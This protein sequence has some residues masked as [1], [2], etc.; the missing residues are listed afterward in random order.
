MTDTQN[1]EANEFERLNT[2]LKE[3][4]L[5]AKDELESLAQS[6]SAERLFVAVTAYMSIAPAELISEVTH[7][8]VSA[9]SE[10]LAFY[11][12]PF[13]G[14]S[15]VNEISPF[16]VNDCVRA[17]EDLFRAEIAKGAYPD[18]NSTQTPGDILSRDVQRQARIVR[19][20][21]YQEQTAEEIKG[22]QGHFDT[23]FDAKTGI[24]PA[25]AVAIL[26]AIAEARK[27]AVTSFMK[28]AFEHAEMARMEWRRAKKE[29]PKRRDQFQHRVL[30]TFKG[31]SDAWVFGRV[32]RQS[33][34]APDQIPT[35]L[36]SLTNLSPPP[37]DKESEGL[38]SLI[39]LTRELRKG[40]SDPIEIR[41]KPLF[42]MPD[43]KVVLIDLANAMDALW[44]AFERV[45][46]SDNRFFDSQY[47]P[48]K[49]KWLEQR[50]EEYL[51]KIF[52]K[53]NIYCGLS[54][55]DL[56]KTDKATAELDIAVSWGPFLVLV[57]AKAKQFRLESQLGDVAR[58]RTDIKKN[59]EDAFE[60][61][62]RA[63]EYITNTSKPEFTEIASGRKLLVDKK[64][65]ER[66]YLLTVS[67]HQLANL[68][69]RLAV[70]KDLG[71][72]KDGE[73]PLSIGLA[74]LELVT[75]F[76]DGPDV[77][78]HYI[79]TRL[80][81]QKRQQNILIDEADFLGAY[82]DTR[83]REERLFKGRKKEAF[84]LIWISGFSDVFDA[85]MMYKRGDLPAPPEIKL[86]VPPEIREI[87]DELRRRMD[88]DARWIAFTLLGMSDEGLGVIAR[89]FRGVRSATLTPGR[90]RRIVHQVGDIV[91]SV[92]AT[93]DQS[94]D[95]LSAR[96]QMITDIEK[97]RRRAPKSIGFGIMVLD[98]S[99]PFECATWIE[100]PWKQEKELED[101]L[102]DEP[103]MMPAP[104][105]KTPGRNEPC[106]CG[107][108]KK[109]KKCC[110]NRQMSAQSEA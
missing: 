60:Q 50:V 78:L 42:V 27:A 108:G 93:L 63:A 6:V 5:R 19:G 15:N 22:V 46:K 48:K 29:R 92:V 110:L 84:D 9:E 1:A 83:F 73:Y 47:Q 53:K 16:Q 61:A 85:W 96:T 103:P 107:S 39:G 23:W 49:A 52:P 20:S 72:F 65:I 28:E 4:A 11:L 45:A 91:I 70:F 109:Y 57:E 105:Q 66:T 102:E 59:V 98:R 97:Y 75:E 38:V 17:L 7:G 87:L 74:D 25:R 12:F 14:V 68:A 58:L 55:P 3:S 24:S 40:I 95:R 41:H 54:Y 86:N 44:D 43:G 94:S 100:Y 77:F 33:E 18:P 30:S 106:I 56:T 88:D 89:A 32:E 67:L 13:F 2:Q 8:T 64:K 99:R 21:A 79:E 35:S 104:G 62:R 26:W 76:C 51:A 10:L 34:L 82:L 69:T 31:E 71:L 81:I 37:S 90:F 101:L 80:D 36:A